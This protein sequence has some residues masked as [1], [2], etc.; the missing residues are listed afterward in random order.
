MRNPDATD[1]RTLLSNALASAAQNAI[2]KKY[3]EQYQE[4]ID[5][6]NAE[7]EKLAGLKAKIKELSF[8]PGKRNTEQIRNLQD[9]AIKTANRINVYDKLSGV[10]FA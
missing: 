9:Q 1:N 4:K 2:E 5:I 3:I 8:A 7:Q 10:Y 6:V